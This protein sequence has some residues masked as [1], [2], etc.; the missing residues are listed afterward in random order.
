MCTGRQ[1]QDNSCL[2]APPPRGQ[3]YSAKGVLTIFKEIIFPLLASSSAFMA[4]LDVTGRRLHPRDGFPSALS[5]LST[6]APGS[7]YK[8]SPSMFLGPLIDG[9]SPAPGPPP[10]TSTLVI[11]LSH[12][13]RPSSDGTSGRSG[14]ANSR[15]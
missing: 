4:A 10:M 14:P 8:A 7:L 3:G 11:P 9:R 2:D 6:A 5:V 12:C 15:R 1:F 13:S